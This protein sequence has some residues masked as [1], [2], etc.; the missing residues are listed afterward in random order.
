MSKKRKIER[1]E[2]MDYKNCQECDYFR[3]ENNVC[4]WGN[5]VKILSIL[6][7]CPLTNRIL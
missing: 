4:L 7:I 5:S 2:F 6:K 1:A 3:I